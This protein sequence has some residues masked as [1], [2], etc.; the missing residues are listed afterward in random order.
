M[1]DEGSCISESG[2]VSR[3]PLGQ[4]ATAEK[5]SSPE[6]IRAGQPPDLETPPRVPEG[7]SYPLVTRMSGIFI[8]DMR[9]NPGQCENGSLY[10][11]TVA[12]RRK[13]LELQVAGLSAVLTLGEP[14]VLS[15]CNEHCA[16][17]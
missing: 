12:A 8:R 4:L 15:R 17:A 7:G 3:G 16:A 9:S 14:E 13:L 10:A 2:L 6:L 5:Q 11:Q 1:I